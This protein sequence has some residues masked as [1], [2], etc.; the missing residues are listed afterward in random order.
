M[1]EEMHIWAAYLSELYWI[2]QTFISPIQKVLS[3]KNFVFCS[4]FF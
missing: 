3:Y 2:E 4:S 1:Y